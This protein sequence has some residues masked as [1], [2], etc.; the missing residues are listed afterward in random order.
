MIHT[1][2]AAPQ[3]VLAVL[4]ACIGLPQRSVGQPKPLPKAKPARK[5][6]I[7]VAPSAERVSVGE[8]VVLTESMPLA[9]ETKV[10]GFR[11]DVFRLGVRD[12]KLNALVLLT[13]GDVS[14][15]SPSDEGGPYAGEDI[16]VTS[17]GTPPPDSFRLTTRMV[18]PPRT[19]FPRAVP[20]GSRRESP[21][22]VKSHRVGSRAAARSS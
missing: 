21:G 22:S 13:W 14:P 6:A 15:V 1:P 18:S 7:A 2:R 20:S 17:T 11:H 8:D 4:I 10:V 19:T 3:L 16:L 12:E 9:G 5:V